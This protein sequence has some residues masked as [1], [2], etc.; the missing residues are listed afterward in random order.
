MKSKFSAALELFGFFFLF[1]V[2]LLS[3]AG[4]C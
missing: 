1:H 2:D 4:S 3:S